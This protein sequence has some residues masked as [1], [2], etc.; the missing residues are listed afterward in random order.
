M[1]C[2]A[3]A[4]DIYTKF[5]LK[6]FWMWTIFKVFIESVTVLLLLCVLVFCPQGKGNRSS[7]TREQ[8]HTP[9]LEGEV[10]TIG[11]Q[12]SPH[13]KIFFKLPL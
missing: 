9:A 4:D 1:F 10:L 13:K 2:A 5:F 3:N 7:Q 11:C 12:G 8:T 6:T